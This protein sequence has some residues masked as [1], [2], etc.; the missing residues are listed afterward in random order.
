[1]AASFAAHQILEKSYPRCGELHDLQ[2]HFILRRL[3]LVTQT[4]PT[5]TS[6]VIQVLASNE[7]DH[8][9]VGVHDEQVSHV[10]VDKNLYSFKQCHLVTGSIELQLN[11]T[12]VSAFSFQDYEN[13]DRGPYR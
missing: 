5:M 2:H 13:A 1:M 3:C 10:Q 7:P 4:P 12:L 9:V 11:L 8:I 6:R